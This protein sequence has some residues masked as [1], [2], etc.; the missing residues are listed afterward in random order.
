MSVSRGLAGAAAV[1]PDMALV[2]LHVMSADSGIGR[3]WRNGGSNA[4]TRNGLKRWSS[5]CCRDI[6]LRRN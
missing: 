1:S 6:E 4:K 5:A 3:R 2:D